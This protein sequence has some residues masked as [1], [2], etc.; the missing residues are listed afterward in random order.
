MT[1]AAR[2]D[3]REMRGKA[4][5]ILFEL[6]FINLAMSFFLAGETGLFHE[7]V[8]ALEDVFAGR[9]VSREA[10]GRDREWLCSFFRDKFDAI[11][12]LENETFLSLVNR[13]LFI[14]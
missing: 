5:G 10:M 13:R 11:A 7:Y 8:K 2:R 1:A 3:V 4:L 14:V 6:E 12:L 9:G